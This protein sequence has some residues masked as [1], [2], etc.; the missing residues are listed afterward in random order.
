MNK[1]IVAKKLPKSD[2]GGGGPAGQGRSGVSLDQEQAQ[3]QRG[4]CCK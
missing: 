2:S 4:S 3:S 1:N